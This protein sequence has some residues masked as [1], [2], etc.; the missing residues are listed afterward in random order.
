MKRTYALVFLAVALVAVAALGGFLVG[1]ERG[2]LKLPSDSNVACT[3]EAKLCPD[4]SGVG[5]EGPNC[6]FPDC[7]TETPPAKPE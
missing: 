3:E 6:E 5:R 7:P 2:R 4:G 1:Q